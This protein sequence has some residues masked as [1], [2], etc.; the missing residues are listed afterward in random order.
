MASTH[1][2]LGCSGAGRVSDAA[3]VL[4]SLEGLACTLAEVGHSEEAEKG[5]WTV[6]RLIYSRKWQEHDSTHDLKPHLFYC[7]QPL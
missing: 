3:E 1:Q 4:L 5:V 7:C 6:M 2:H